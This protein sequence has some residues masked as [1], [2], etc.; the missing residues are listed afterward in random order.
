MAGAVLHIN[1]ARLQLPIFTGSNLHRP[2]SSS[3]SPSSY[4]AM[5]VSMSTSQSYW[6]SINENIEVHLKQAVRIREPLVVFEPVHNLTFSAPRTPASALCIA[7]CELVGGHR[8][9]ALP[10][11]AALHLLH[12]ATYAHDHL[13]SPHGPMK[14]PKA[15]QGFSPDIVLLAADGLWPLGY[16]LITGSDDSSGSMSDR[17]LRVMVEVARAVGAEGVIDGQYEEVL[18]QWNQSEH[19]VK[20][21]LEKKEGGL[22]ACAAACGAILGGGS[23]EA[24]DKLRKYGL[25]VGMIQGICHRKER[26][27]EIAIQMVQ[28]LRELALKEIEEFSGPQVAAISSLVNV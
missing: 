24:I 18:A 11:A 14:R 17:I 15:H 1:V 16:E 12:A 9:Q 22:Q 13:L 3:P 28:G 27:E 25:Y 5:R 4:R 21:V 26:K 6:S 7:A 2:S 19:R 10:T 8:N 20:Y 23:E